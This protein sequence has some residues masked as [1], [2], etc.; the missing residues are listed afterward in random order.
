M[1][2]ASGFTAKPR[3]TDMFDESIQPLQGAS[4]LTK[5]QP[6]HAAGH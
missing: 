2:D 4:T 3:K 6:G 5:Q 1:D